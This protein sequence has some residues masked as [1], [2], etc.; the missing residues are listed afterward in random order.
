MPHR[1]IKQAQKALTSDASPE[2]KKFLEHLYGALSDEDMDLLDP[3]TMARTAERHWKMSANRKPLASEI[4]IYTPRPDRDDWGT[5]HTIIDIVSEDMVFLVDSVAAEITAR[6]NR[7]IHVLVHPV[8]YG[9]QRKNGN[10]IPTSV[11]PGKGLQPQSHI[12]ME[13]QGTMPDSLIPSLKQDLQ[14]ILNDVYFATRD[15]EQMREKLKD[16]QKTLSH[17]PK[18][19]HNDKLQDYLNF[20]EYLHNDN[21]TLLGYREYKFT[22]NKD[23]V[24]SQTV[25]GSSLGLLHNDVHPVY[26]SEKKDGLPQDLQRL[27]HALPPLTVSKVNKKSTVHRP[28]P[29]DAIAVKQ[30]DKKGNITGECLF[31]GLF[32]SVTYSRSIQDIP[33]LSRKTELVMERSGFKPGSHDFKALRHILEKYPRDELFQIEIDSLLKTALS[34][35][36]LQERQRIALYTRKDPFGRY[37]SCL[38]YV[39]KDRYDT[40]LR[41]TIQ[42]ILEKDM[43]GTCA[44][45]YTNL[46][47]SP[48]ARVMYIIYINQGKPPRFETGKTEARLQEAGRLW[49]EK[50]ADTLLETSRNEERI[51]DIIQK[52]GRAFPISYRE[53]FTPKQ[54]IFDIERIEEALESEH[55]ALDIYRCNACSDQQLRLKIYHK[56]H[57]VILSDILPILDKMG[58][59]VLSE[60][61]FNV[62]PEGADSS[63]WIHDFMMET[64]EGTPAF[65]VLDI[66][67]QFEEALGKIWCGE[68]ENAGLNR[69]ILGAH[70]NWREVTILRT[71]IRFMR[72]A[73]HPFSTRYIEQA[74]TGNP[75]ISRHIIVLF[76]A[77]HNPVKTDQADIGAAGCSVAIDHA[78]E[79]V[80]S[81]DED[82][83]LRT[84]VGLVEATLRTNFFQTDKAGNPKSWLAIKLDSR[85]IDGL[86]EPKPYREIFVYSPQ[87]EGIHLRG[88]VIARGGIR[89]SDRHE[90]FRTEVL[91]LMK[92][93][94]VKNSLIVPMG[95]K[96]GF[97]VK[98]PPKDGGREA[99][100]KEGISCYKIFIRA[101]LDITDNRKGKKVVPPKDVVR[102]DG[103]DPYLVVA[104]DKGTATFSDIANSLSAEYGHWLGDAFA[105]GGSA[106]YDHKKMGITARGAWESVKRHFRELNHNTQTEPFDVVGVGDMAGDVFGNGM[107][108]SN[109]IRMIGAFNHLHIVCDPDPDPAVSFKER[110][111][112]FNAV[113]GWDDYDS[114]KLSKG[115]KIYLRSEKNLTL[116]P[117]IRKRFDL[118]SDRATPADLIQ[119]MLRARTDLLWFGGIGTYIK[120]SQ[121]THT[122]AGDKANDSLRINASEIRTRVIGEGANL[123]VTQ[124][125]RIEF[126]EK[127]GK[128]NA[129]FIDNSGG[130]DSSDREVNIK[131]LFTE[132]MANPDHK[133]TLKKRNNLLEKMTDEVAE[134]VLRDN[135]QQSQGLSLM[136]L[137]AAEHLSAHARFITDLERNN[138]LNRK[139]E[140]LP[141]EEEIELRLRNGKGLTRPEL[142]L[143]QAY[144]KI[145]FTTDL[146]ASDIPD[147]PEIGNYWLFNYFPQPLRKKY[148]KE[149]QIHRLRREIIATSMA[150]SLV[151]RMGP[152]FVKG[153]M[154]KTGANC[155]DVARAYLVVRDSFGLRPLWDQIE[156]L[157]NKVPAQ[158]QLKAMQDIAKMVERETIWFLTRLGRTPDIITDIKTFG[159]GVSTLCGHL[160]EI[161]TEELKQSIQQRTQLGINDGLSHTL[162]EQIALIP[163]LGAACDIVRIS[164]NSHRDILLA[165]RTYFELGE[166]FHIDWFRQQARY[167]TAD[168]RW[169]AEALDALT[170]QFH[171][172]QAGL[173]IHILDDMKHGIKNKKLGRNGHGSIVKAWAE[174]HEQQLHLFESLFADI[175]RVGT[176]D[177]PMLVIAEQRLR[178]LYGG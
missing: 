46:D 135:Y 78:L 155:A 110:K 23:I 77:L 122:D 35:L 64:K 171:S 93:Q 112:L 48:L 102:R 1:L 170:E 60:L 92:A 105:S 11:K 95:A 10:V 49:S 160:D 117:E 24:T 148:E 13:L 161:V 137:Q 164:R 97:V 167:M 75:D 174:N 36:R 82:R 55:M 41:I 80:T 126:S 26:I 143:I 114:K 22:K 168:D 145:L 4:Y 67:P 101:L 70:M 33:Y 69:L 158:V 53:T 147:I 121:E 128:I 73:R 9:E 88:D 165:A 166:Y 71:Y 43:K 125:A 16:C 37:I 39:P 149:I 140:E 134:L 34:I 15:W 61:P 6:H 62:K 31:I 29:L 20:L 156:S 7:L 44:N 141:D 132:V 57:P 38:V 115:G 136:E 28:V 91:G 157:D 133:I 106:G 150:T 103:D 162:A 27:R 59:N 109:K 163:T 51:P 81:L 54:A 63:I 138:G 119:A 111:R 127:G 142:S 3:V 100:L 74:L 152:T 19:H 113:K 124:A 83:V 18:S 151:N 86:P 84:I 12:H 25:R 21:F 90:D 139:L 47:D 130:V 98:N 144:A 66:K 8:L 76:N 154:D 42:K 99:F 65:K 40:R 17:T 14:Q 129:D 118:D 175:R 79:K 5:A 94:Q 104:A 169:S 159:K 107:L 108:L 45:F 52:Y 120:A 56:N 58:L 176:I 2:L 72:Q 87:V 68:M 32:T 50:L 172:C 89:W 116:T 153:L 123:G 85:S 178:S 173:T 96:G 146:L 177:L 131:I 30:F